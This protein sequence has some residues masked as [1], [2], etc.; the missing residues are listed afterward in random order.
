MLATG[1]GTEVF[2]RSSHFDGELEAQVRWI[3][4]VACSNTEDEVG[5]FY[6]EGGGSPTRDE[7]EAELDSRFDG[8]LD[9]P[10]FL[11]MV[12][13]ALDAKSVAV[14]AWDLRAERD[15]NKLKVLEIDT[16]FEIE[17][18]HLSRTDEN[19]FVVARSRSSESGHPVERCHVSKVWAYGA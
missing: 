15:E 17:S 10:K 13:W 5:I 6:V 4:L 14:P 2:C 19:E 11:P 3:D 16:A 7:A 12:R 1:S 18:L 8:C 9:A